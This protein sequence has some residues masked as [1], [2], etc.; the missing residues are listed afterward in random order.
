VNIELA[1]FLSLELL[2]CDF[3]Y[4]VHFFNKI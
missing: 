2:T 4:N 3:Y 1:T